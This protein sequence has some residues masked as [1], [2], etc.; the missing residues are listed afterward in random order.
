M[1]KVLIKTNIYHLIGVRAGN[2]GILQRTAKK[3]FGQTTFEVCV[4]DETLIFT[5]DEIEFINENERRE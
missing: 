5:E 3:Y 1:Q 4:D 2:L